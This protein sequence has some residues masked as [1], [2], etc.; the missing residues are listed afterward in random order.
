VN[1]ADSDNVHV[2]VEVTESDRLAEA[3][4]ALD[5]ETV[6]EGVMDSVRDLLASTV[7]EGLSVADL[8]GPSPVSVPVGDIISVKVIEMVM[9]A[10]AVGVLPVRLSETDGDRDGENFETEGEAE[11]LGDGAVT[12]GIELSESDSECESDGLKVPHVRDTVGDTL[13]VSLM[14]ELG[15][16]FV[17]ERVIDAEPDTVLDG[18]PSETVA[19]TMPVTVVVAV[20]G[21]VPAV[22]LL[23][24]DPLDVTSLV[25]ELVG[26]NVAERMSVMDAVKDNVPVRESSLDKE[27][28]DVN[29][30]VVV[31]DAVRVLPSGDT[32][33][34]LDTVNQGVR[35]LVRDASEVHDVD[36]DKLG[37]NVGVMLS[38]GSDR[39]TVGVLPVPEPVQVASTE[40]LSDAERDTSNVC[41]GETELLNV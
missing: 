33:C 13:G 4:G 24:K 5:V 31:S 12:V 37:E 40:K 16:P 36:R 18:V 6:N 8:V 17:R 27:I 25:R 32:V 39:V 26:E 11:I 3:D 1:E 23:E 21:A 7:G 14:V 41:V 15:V 2:I 38:V 34:E 29:R 19:V 20:I 30:S 22:R 35:V 10:V 9:E 28:V